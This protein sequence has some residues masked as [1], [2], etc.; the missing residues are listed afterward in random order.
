MVA[1]LLPNEATH[2]SLDLFEKPALLVTFDGSFCQKL[3]PV[4]SPDAPMLEFEKFFCES[5]KLLRSPVTFQKKFF[6][7]SNA[8]L[9][10]LRELISNMTEQLL[11]TL[12]EPMLLTFAIMCCFHFSLHSVSQR[13]ENL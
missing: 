10:S 11:L 5:M 7:K 9:F 3:G 1:N 4:Y 2:S 8:K 6:W 12:L 13:I